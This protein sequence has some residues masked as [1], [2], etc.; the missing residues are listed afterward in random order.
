MENIEG[1]ASWRFGE[2]I[3]SYERNITSLVL[4]EFQDNETPRKAGSVIGVPGKSR[5]KGRGAKQAG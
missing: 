5:A 2:C 4:S 3:I 1:G